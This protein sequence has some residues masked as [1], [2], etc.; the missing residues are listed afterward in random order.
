MYL[1]FFFLLAK[2]IR[3]LKPRDWLL[4]ENP[5][6]N[7]IH[8]IHAQQKPGQKDGNEGRTKDEQR[9]KKFI[10]SNKLIPFD[11][12]KNHFRIKDICISLIKFLPDTKASRREGESFCDILFRQVDAPPAGSTSCPSPPPRSPSPCSSSA[13]LVVDESLGA[14]PGHARTRRTL[15][16]NLVFIC[17]FTVRKMNAGSWR[18]MWKDMEWGDW[19]YLNFITRGRGRDPDCL[20]ICRPKDTFSSQLPGLINQLQTNYI[21]SSW[22][23]H[24]H[25][26]RSFFVFVILVVVEPNW[27][28]WVVEP[29]RTS[30]AKMSQDIISQSQISHKSEWGPLFFHLMWKAAGKQKPTQQNTNKKDWKL[31]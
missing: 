14:R 17:L 26:N 1:N 29:G 12:I 27:T 19:L 2:L 6:A 16:E 10:K 24:C 23:C 20:R 7:E 18:R 11:P 8:Y 5:Q 25:W 4:R 30:W 21:I 9:H 31:I 22:L 3:R 28:C 15:R 13:P